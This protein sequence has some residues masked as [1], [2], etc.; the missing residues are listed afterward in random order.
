MHQSFDTPTTFSDILSATNS[1]GTPTRVTAPQPLLGEQAEAN[2]KQAFTLFSKRSFSNDDDESHHYT[3]TSNFLEDNSTL[4]EESSSAKSDFSSNLTTDFSNVFSR[5]REKGSNNGGSSL[6]H[7]MAD[8]QPGVNT[9]HVPN[10]TGAVMPGMSTGHPASKP[11]SQPASQSGTPRTSLD[12]YS[13][14]I[15]LSP[16]NT[17]SAVDNKGDT[18][19]SGGYQTSDSSLPALQP[20]LA[21]PARHTNVSM[22]EFFPGVITLGNQT[23]LGTLETQSQVASSSFQISAATPSHQTGIPL[24]NQQ[25]S[26]TTKG[27]QTGVNTEVGHQAT[28]PCSGTDL[29]NFDNSLTWKKKA[30]NQFTE[31]TQEFIYIFSFSRYLLFLQL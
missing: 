16:P 23:K 31:N 27:F 17:A 10:F 19:Q 20:C 28:V 9:V 8:N 26:L 12:G 30:S 14:Y 11:A 3:T 5:I 21:E 4:C 25:A 24:P 18:S 1:T 6:N 29:T 13:N 22:S 2:T 7:S 15:V